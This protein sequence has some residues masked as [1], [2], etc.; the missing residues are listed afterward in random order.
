M[1]QAFAVFRGLVL[2]SLRD[3]YTLFWDLVFPLVLLVILVSIFGNIGNTISEIVFD[4]GLVVEEDQAGGL[5]PVGAVVEG[6][7]REMAS[8]GPSWLN[9]LKR[10]S[11]DE[12]LSALAEGRR[13]AV[14]HVSGAEVTVHVQEGRMLSEIAGDTLGQVLESVN[15]EINRRLGLISS[16]SVQTA[17]RN[18][19]AAAGSPEQGGFDFAAY[20]VPGII[21]MVFLSSGLGPMVQHLGV[22]RELG[23]L[24]R[25]FAAP[26]GRGQYFAG[27]LFYILALSLVQVCLIYGVGLLLFGVRLNLLAWDAVFFMVL[28]LAALLALGFAISAAAKTANAAAALSNGLMYPMMFLGGLYFPVMQ[29]PYPFKLIVLANPVTYLVNGL[30]HSLGVFTSPTPPWANVVAPLCFTALMLLVGLRKFKWDV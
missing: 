4:V 15:V 27:I 20:M 6:A 18:V 26:L 16:A 8:G 25:L 10:G 9:L 13:H 1:R 17:Y 14:V 11:L 30:R 21:L 24:R 29:L 19:E 7:L 28:A 2:S 23:R 3:K 5:L 12:E 22:D